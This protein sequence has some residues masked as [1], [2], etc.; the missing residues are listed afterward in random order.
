MLNTEGVP[1]SDI[2][3]SPNKD[4]LVVMM[5]GF[6]IGHFAIDAQGQLTEL[7]KVKLSGRAQVA[8]GGGSQ[9]LVWAGS[10]CLAILTGQKSLTT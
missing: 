7:A 5:E 8:R 2:L 1:L 4:S 6:T 3:H 10:S 9:G